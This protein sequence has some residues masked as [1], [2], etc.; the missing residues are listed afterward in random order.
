MGKNNNSRRPHKRRSSAGSIEKQ[1]AKQTEKFMSRVSSL[2]TVEVRRRIGTSQGFNYQSIAPLV[3]VNEHLKLA[4]AVNTSGQTDVFY[5]GN[6]EGNR[7]VEVREGKNLSNPLGAAGGGKGLFAKV[8]IPAGTRVCPYVGVARSC[9]CDAEVGCRYDVRVHADFYLCAR[10]VMYDMG[11]LMQTDAETYNARNSIQVKRPCPVNFGR[12][13][14]S[15]TREQLEA[16]LVY[17][18]ALENSDDGVD[19]LFVETLEFIPA[20][21]ELVMDYGADFTV[22]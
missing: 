16:G 9:P 18:C 1:N 19:V 13:V 3:P 4:K 22:A 5:T 11:Y 12:Y 20:G 6:I 8:D 10:D 17:N 21:D 7:W 14:N 15:L 2:R